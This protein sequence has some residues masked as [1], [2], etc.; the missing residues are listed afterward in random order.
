[1]KTLK[2]RIKDLAWEQKYLKE[3]RKTVN[4]KGVRPESGSFFTVG[5]KPV[6]SPIHIQ[7]QELHSYNRADLR[8]LYA[9]YAIL[10]GKDPLKGDKNFVMSKYVQNL[11]DKYE[12]ALYP[13][14]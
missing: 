6:G 4:F 3:Q 9:A 2:E 8:A 12:E 5:G 13:S 7:A 14:K 11:V 10:R 1:M